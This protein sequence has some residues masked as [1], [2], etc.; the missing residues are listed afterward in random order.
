MDSNFEKRFEL[1]FRFHVNLSSSVGR[2]RFDLLMILCNMDI[3]S[4]KIKH[5]TRPAHLILAFL[6]RLV[7]EP[8]E[9]K[10]EVQ[11]YWKEVLEP[12]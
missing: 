5:R 3:R 8:I 4:N 11:K 7:V 9:P 1:C 10:I 6:F 2:S 12:N